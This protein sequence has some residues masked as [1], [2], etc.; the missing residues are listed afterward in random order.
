MW[1]QFDYLSSWDSRTW[2]S[3]LRTIQRGTRPAEAS[4]VTQCC[5]PLDAWQARGVFAPHTAPT[6]WGNVFHSLS[7]NWLKYA[8]TYDE[9]NKIV[10]QRLVIIAR[11]GDKSPFMYTPFLLASLSFLLCFMIDV[12]VFLCTNFTMKGRV[13]PGRPGN[14]R[15][16]LMS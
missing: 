10:N 9:V 4:E 13:M 14:L 1:C 8:L 7:C 16:N 3:F 6:R 12:F 2:Y 15:L 11:R 5:Q